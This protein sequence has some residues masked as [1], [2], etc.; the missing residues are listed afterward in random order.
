MAWCAVARGMHAYAPHGRARARVVQPKAAAVRVPAQ[1][2][3]APP[4][5]TAPARAAH[6]EPR[7]APAG[8]RPRPHAAPF[9]AASFTVLGSPCR[10]SVSCATAGATGPCGE[11]TL[12]DLCSLL[13]LPEGNVSA[14]L[15]TLDD[16]PVP[17]PLLSASSVVLLSLARP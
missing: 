15:H 17:V 5:D 2:F 6:A 11:Y 3:A 9:H 13:V 8:R 12:L 10:G 1:A 14:P 4:A 16:A 7:H